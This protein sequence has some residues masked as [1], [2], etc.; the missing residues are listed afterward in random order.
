MTNKAVNGNQMTVC[1]HVDNLKVSHCDSVQVTIF[2][3]WL[4]RKYR[5]AV[6]THR[7]KV[8]DYLV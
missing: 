1:W 6:A 4:S 7:G 5:V 8:A 2:G 3:E